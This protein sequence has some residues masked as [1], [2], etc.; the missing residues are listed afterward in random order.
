MATSTYKVTFYD[1][2]MEIESVQTYHN[3]DGDSTAGNLILARM[4]G[5][6]CPFVQVLKKDIEDKEYRNLTDGFYYIFREEIQRIY[7][8]IF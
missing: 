4:E 5:L 8:T 3:M 7:N 6:K 1:S 2:L